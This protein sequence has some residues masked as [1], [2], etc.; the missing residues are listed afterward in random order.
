M[1]AQSPPL[2]RGWTTGACATAAVKAA[3]LKL[4]AGHF[5]DEVSI[6]LPR[7]ETPDFALEETAAGDGW[8]AAGIIKDA[9]DD[10][11][12]THGALITAK[13]TL[14]GD[15]IEFRAGKGVGTVTKPGLPL[16]VGEPAI[17]PVPREMMRGVVE[18]LAQEYGATPCVVIEISIRDG[19]DLAKKTW[20]PR[21][22]IVG[23]LSVLGTTG[24]VRPFS[25]AAWIASIHRGVDVA[26]ATGLTHVAGCTG[27]T[28]EKVVQAEYDL[29]EQAM[30]DMGDFAGGLLKYL[31]KHPVERLTIGGGIG[32]MTKLAQGAMDLHSGR[33][34]IDFDALAKAL[35]EP[36][37]TD[38]NSALEVYER[39]GEKFSAFVANGALKTARE[40][41][42]DSP[43]A[44]DLILIDRAGNIIGRA[45]E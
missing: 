12:V 44:L 43:V 37:I 32:K 28:S 7:G 8:A 17:N 34:Q 23:G 19:E 14:G 13:V 45:A 41:L 15:G 39:Y 29:F 3:L 25:C 2:R 1:D 33:S 11:D 40:V 31:R 22:G 20:N 27:A 35:G 36:H 4:W 38:C 5:P 16:A 30:L 24:V 9:G 10:P 21:L 6:T 42:R 18:E 26:R